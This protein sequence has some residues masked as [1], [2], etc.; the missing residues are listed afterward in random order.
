MN[1][2]DAYCQRLQNI[3]SEWAI[4]K[5]LLQVIFDCRLNKN[6]KHQLMQILSDRRDK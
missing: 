5:I 2:Y 3:N 4:I 6:E 1:R